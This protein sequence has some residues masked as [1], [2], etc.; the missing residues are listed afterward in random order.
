VFNTYPAAPA[1]PPP[2]APG[3]TPTPA[4][5]TPPIGVSVPGMVV[6]TPNQQQPPGFPGGNVPVPD[7][8]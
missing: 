3:N 8:P 5:G 1:P 6:P 2:N 7:E 4:T